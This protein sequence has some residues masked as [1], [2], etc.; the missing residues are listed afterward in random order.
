MES[1]YTVEY[2]WIGGK[3]EL[4]SKTRV[5]R[6]NIESIKDIPS[7]NY[8]G[9]STG[10][11]LGNDSEVIITP[12]ALFTSSY[13]NYIP[14]LFN[15]NHIFVL[16]DT[17][18]VDGTPH[19]TNKRALANNI[20][21]QKLEAEPWY[22]MEQEYFIMA[23]KNP[24]DNSRIP[25]GYTGAKK[26]GQYY[27]SV[28]S[29]NAFGRIIAETHMRMCIDL[30]INIS[31]I[32]AEVAP[33]QWEFQIGPCVGIETG[34]HLWMARYL[35]QKIAESF[36]YHICFE[37][38]PLKGD[39]NGSGCHTNY[40]TKLMR[41]GNKET[42]EKG[43][44]Y[45]NEAIKKLSLS[46]DDHMLIYG[47][48]NKSRMTGLHETASY[49]NFTCGIAN[50]GASVRIGNETIHNE[51]GYFEDRRPSSNCDPYIVTSVIFK[52]TVLN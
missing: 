5:L 45:I 49:K 7:W 20:F 38:K 12:R 16:C 23:E 52:T 30:G 3:Q 1:I 44:H 47:T 13:N 40:S 51:K 50:R 32:N 14:Y 15:Q 39:W 27:C 46:H 37:P 17:Y 11:A 24:F 22:G 28:G 31:G 4:R 10:Q 33:G 18:K 36:N 34:D 25:L 2:V 29:D 6:Q 19:P 35:I 21:N 48:D 8:D 9:S 43:I 26:Q 42:G 41:E